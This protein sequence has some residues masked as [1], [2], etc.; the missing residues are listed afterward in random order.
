MYGHQTGAEI[1]DN[2]TKP[3]RPS[4]TLHTYWI[5]NIRLVLDVEV[6]SGKASAAKHSLPRLRQL[7]ERLPPEERPALVRG[8]SAFGNQ[9][10]RSELNSTPSSSYGKLPELS[11]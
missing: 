11:V 1:G 2:P 7:I 5:G 3:G 6:Q 8:D 9:G 4:H 10:I